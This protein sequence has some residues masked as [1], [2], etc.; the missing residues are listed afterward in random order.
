MRAW[1]TIDGAIATVTSLVVGE[2]SGRAVDARGRADLPCSHNAQVSCPGLSAFDPAAQIVHAASPLPENR[3]SGHRVHSLRPVEEP[4]QPAAHGTH[5]GCACEF[6]IYT[7]FT[8][9]STQLL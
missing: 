1:F 8:H 9:E 4:N 7:L 3:P 5:L 6:R 2:C